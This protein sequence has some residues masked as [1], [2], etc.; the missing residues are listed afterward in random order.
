MKNLLVID[1]STPRV[2]VGLAMGNGKCYLMSAEGDRRHGRDLI[3]QIGAIL[4]EAGLTISD[5]DVIGVGIGPGS[6]TGLRVGVTAAKTLAYASGASL[7][8]LDSLHA[9]A[10]NAPAD[11]LQICVI[12]DAQRSDLYVA[13]FVRQQP[14]SALAIAAGSHIEPLA[15]WLARIEPATLVM[16]PGLTSPRIRAS[17]PA[18]CPVAEPALDY[19][20]GRGLIELARGG[21]ASGRRADPWLL[22]PLYLRRSAAEDQWDARATPRLDHVSPPLGPE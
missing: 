14:G 8:A 7:L 6:Y 2:A 9:I 15:S 3:P 4:G 17:L 12:A 13:D 11:A 21:W 10:F 1:T 16:G 20:E 19:P 18:R 5:V 22:E